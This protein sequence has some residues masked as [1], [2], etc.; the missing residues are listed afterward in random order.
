MSTEHTAQNPP[1]TIRR[2][3]FPRILCAVDGSPSAET[4]IEQALTLAGTDA[5]LTF[6]A[7]CDSRGFGHT[8]MA[9]LGPYRADAALDAARAAAREAGAEARMIVRHAEDVRHT[10]FEA[11]SAHDLLVLGTHGQQR[12]AGIV[13][14]TTAVAALHHAPV[15]VLIARRPRAD[16]AFPQ[17]ILLASDGSPTMGPTVATAA[18]L[19]RRHDARVTLVHIGRS[20]SGIRHELAEEIATLIDVTGREPEVAEADGHTASRLAELAANL[21]T[22]LIVTGSRELT[23]IRALG[24]VSERTGAIAPCSVLVMRGAS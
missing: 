7:V 15:P 16:A 22:S 18:A 1:R 11:A 14:G 5:A 3:P 6:M 13:L 10:I 9:S 21:H 24:S 2:P 23:G 17:R 8:R 20:D 4:A 19:A 12:P